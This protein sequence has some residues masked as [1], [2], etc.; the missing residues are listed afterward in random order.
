MKRSAFAA[1]LVPLALS[2][3]IPLPTA[4][5]AV[6]VVEDGED[7]TMEA[8]IERVRIGHGAKRLRVRVTFDNLVRGPEPG[9]SFAVFLDTDEE[10]PGP[11][12][13]LSAGL[14]RGTD[15]TFSSITRWQGRG[16]H[17]NRC[18]YDLSVNWKQDVAVFRVPNKCLRRPESVGVAV[19]VHETFPRSN[20]KVDWLTGNR[21][22]SDP[23]AVG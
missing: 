14:N 11:E 21:L 6:L 4:T 5:A 12:F 23:V 17:V 15:Y 10:D 1:V 18:S 3:V 16:K 13:R 7:S 19:R 8:D 20:L 9:Q 22:F 2:L